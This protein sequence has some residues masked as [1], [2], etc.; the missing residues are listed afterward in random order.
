MWLQGT[1]R[2]GEGSPPALACARCYMHFHPGGLTTI[3][4]AAWLGNLAAT[5]ATKAAASS[6]SAYGTETVRRA[7]LVMRPSS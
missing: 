7:G 4:L 1:S 5:R 3:S 6:Q 2:N